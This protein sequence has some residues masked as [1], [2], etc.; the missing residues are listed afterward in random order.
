MRLRNTALGAAAGMVCALSLLWPRPTC[1][2]EI[3]D[4]ERGGEWSDE[5]EKFGQVVVKAELVAA[6]GGWTLVRTVINTSAEPQTVAVEERIMRAESMLDARVDGTPMVVT[7]TMRTFKLGPHERQKIGITL[8]AALGAEMTAARTT[9]NAAERA[10]I[11]VEETGTISAAKYAAY[12]TRFA[13]FFP[14]YLKPLPPG[15]TAK[16]PDYISGPGRMPGPSEPP[17]PAYAMHGTK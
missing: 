13:N 11:V 12:S 2:E 4:S 6:V 8:P 7:A 9:R 5:G 3:D 10:R 14:Q 15:A 17:S 16:K 1:A